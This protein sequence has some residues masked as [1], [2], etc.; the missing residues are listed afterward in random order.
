MEIDGRTAL[1]TGAS[2]GIGEQFARQLAAGGANLVLLARRGDALRSLQ[3]ELLQVHP[4]LTVQVVVADLSEAAGA[5]QVGQQLAST[6]TVVDLLINNA[7]VG[8]HELFVE[9]DPSA[10]NRQIQLNVASLV[11]LTALYLPGMLTRGSGAVVN[12]ASTAA[13]QP[14]PTMAVYGATK[15]F[16]LSFSEALWGETRGSGVRVLALCPGATET[17]FFDATGKSFLTGRRQSPQQVVA[18]ALRA[19]SGSSPTIVAGWGNRIDATGYRFL[20][21]ALMVRISAR[22]VRV[23][24]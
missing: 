11:A 16:V 15:A 10:L 14:V 5:D 18:V 19:L 2:G 21:R 3:A 24:A 13:F 22:K 12:V 4:E 20:P 6:G 17:A 7:G 23:T 9:E 1:V 8:S